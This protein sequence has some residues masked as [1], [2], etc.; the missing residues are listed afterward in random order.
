[1]MTLHTKL[2]H[3]ERI[4]DELVLAYDQ[5]EKCR[6]RARLASGDEVALFMVRGTVLRDGELLTGAEGRVVR[7]VAASEP[8]YVVHCDTPLTMARCA[9]HLGNRHTQAQIG[10]GFLRIRVDAVLK[11]MVEG[12][13]ARVEQQDAPF[14]P[15]AGAY[16]GGGYS[17]AHDGH[18]LAPVPLRQKIHRPGDP[19]PA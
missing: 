16:A 15:E 6:L 8:T 1:M 2:A 7:V 12:L 17:H 19:A 11:E 14:E 4:D 9:F 3:A 5:R 13:G 10:E 18:P